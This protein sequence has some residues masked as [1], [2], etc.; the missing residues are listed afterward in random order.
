MQRDVAVANDEFWIERIIFQSSLFTLETYIL[1]CYKRIAANFNYRGYNE[2]KDD[3]L[4]HFSLQFMTNALK[5][6]RS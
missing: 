4:T 6:W 1:S 5:F 3:Y 2:P